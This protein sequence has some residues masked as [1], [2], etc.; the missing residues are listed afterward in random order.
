MKKRVVAALLL[1]WG[2]SSAARADNWPAWRGADGQGHCGEKGLPL[3]WGPS[4]NVRWKVALPDSGSSTPAVWEDRVFVT[5]A[6]EKTGWPPKGGNGGT[7]KARKRS[8]LCFARADG[9]L[10]WQADVIYDEEESTHPTNPFC[11][12]SPATDG[13]RVVVSHGS[14]GL[15]CY[16]LSGKELW[17][18]DAGKM[19]HQ[20]GNASSPVLYEDLCILWCG[21]GE[22]QFLLAV[23]K[24]TGA[25]V[26]QHDEAPGDG[27]KFIGS[28]S[29]PILA[30]VDGKDQL[31]LS[32]VQKLKGFDPKTGKELW[33]C[34]G[35]GNLVYT[36][37][38]LADGIAVAMSG[39]G[40]PA[41]AVKL[42]GSG[43]ITKDRLWQTPRNPQRIGSGVIADGHVYM[44]E[45]DGNPHCFELKSGQELWKGQIEKRPAGGAWG[46][47]LHLDG[48]L[49]ITDR[50]GT[51]M[52]FAAN[53]KFELLGTNRLGE[54]TDASIA[55][56]NGD[57]F[58]RTYKSLW[59][60]SEK[61]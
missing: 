23:N 26:W 50:G 44:V 33:S 47:M 3:K 52:I 9:K 40:G 2:L 46:S 56:S 6:S 45:D 19:E 5:Q 1:V 35:L 32:V 18:V 43:D 34:D 30:K 20:W 53:P 57:L 7:A 54:H 25:K 59:C 42:G 48:K 61:K 12:A 24:K 39:Y 16:D 15:H 10:L 8:L 29:T 55:V 14:A 49:Y 27:K 37:P 60:I 38:L 22:K 41:L 28:W 21:P 58:I 31:I 36:S 13:E 17:K 11:S 4:E 51:T